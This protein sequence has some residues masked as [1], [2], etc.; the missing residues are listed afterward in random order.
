MAIGLG[1]DENYLASDIPALLAKTRRVIP[2]EDGEVA[3]LTP[4]MVVLTDL[5]GDEIVRDPIE[6]TWDAEAAEK[7]GY[8]HFVRKEID[9]QPTALADTLRGRLEGEHIHLPELDDLE[10]DGIRA[11]YLVAAG[12]SFYAGQVGKLLFEKWARL[13]VEVAWGRATL[14][15]TAVA[16]S[17]VITQPVHGGPNQ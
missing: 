14:N 10:L 5:A 13:P 8:D 9:E 12:T 15:P 4:G 17:K 2:L 3:E 1:E 11:V 6:V 16:D 7:G